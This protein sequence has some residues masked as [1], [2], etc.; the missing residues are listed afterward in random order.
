LI[1]IDSAAA[2]DSPDGIDISTVVDGTVLVI[3]AEKTRWQVAQDVRNRIEE[4]GGYLIGVLLNEVRFHI[5]AP[6]YDRL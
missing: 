2:A 1:L 6:I 3:G 5:P 4:R